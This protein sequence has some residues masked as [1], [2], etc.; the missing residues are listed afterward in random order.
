M[1]LIKEILKLEKLTLALDRTQWEF[2]GFKINYLILAIVYKN[3]AVPIMFSLLREKGCSGYEER[4]KLFDDFLLENKSNTIELVLA[5]RE[6]I[7]GKWFRYLLGKSIPFM[8]R[9]KNNSNVDGKAAYLYATDLNCEEQKYLGKKN[10]YGVGVY[11]SIGWTDKMDL[12]V[13]V[14]DKEHKM[15]KYRIRWSIESMFK[16]LKTDGFNL[17][18]THLRDRER[19]S[20]LMGILAIVLAV[21]LVVSEKLE[22]M[23]E[24]VKLNSKKQ[25]Y[26]SA[27][28]E[29]LDCIVSYLTNIEIY[30]KHFIKLIAFIFPSFLLFHTFVG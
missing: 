25:K 1:K 15:K 28:R 5:D 18:D 26:K 14:S 27:F 8:I 6:F 3:I 13:I 20:T 29:G 10:V 22:Q 23:G 7:G 21:I 12:M 4:V 17:E 11:V 9:I 2:A 30:F 19:L 24:K 16:K